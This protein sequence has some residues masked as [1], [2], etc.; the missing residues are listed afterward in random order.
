MSAGACSSESARVSAAV[1][2]GAATA[3][4]DAETV[5]LVGYN[6]MQWRPVTMKSGHRRAGVDCVRQP[7]GTGRRHL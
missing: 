4:G 6:D 2:T 3:G 7:R 1:A 5:R